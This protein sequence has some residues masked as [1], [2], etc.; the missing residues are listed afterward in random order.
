MVYDPDATSP[1]WDRFLEEIFDGDQ[2]LMA[3]MRRMAGC[4]LTGDT[5]EQIVAV[6]H[7]A[8]GNRSRSWSSWRPPRQPRSAGTDTVVPL[9]RG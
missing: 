4:T 5:R 8:G 3:F 9:G 7:G 6:L 2:E 1:R